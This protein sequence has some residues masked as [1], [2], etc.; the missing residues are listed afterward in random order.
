M[1]CVQRAP[2][3]C[4]ASIADEALVATLAAAP[5]GSIEAL[6]H[7][8]PQFRMW[9]GVVRPGSGAGRGTGVLALQD[10]PEGAF[11]VEFWGA[12]LPPCCGPH[13]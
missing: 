11:L 7:R 5:R 1:G 2:K 6:L 4:E 9:A 10:I 13:L 8:G 3:L 12:H